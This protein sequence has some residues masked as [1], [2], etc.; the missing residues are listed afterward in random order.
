MTEDGAGPS[1]PLRQL[2]QYFRRARSDA[3]LT[4]DQVSAHMEWSPSK[5]SRLERGQPGKLTNRDIRTL[6]EFL[7]FETEQTAAMLGLAQQAAVKSWWHAFGDLIPENFNVYV[8]MESSARHLEIFRPD[9]IPGLFQTAD[10]TRVLD[11]IYFPSGSAE[12]HDMR[13][14]V[15]M[16]RQKI[17]TRKIKPVT[18]DVV[19]HESVLRTIVGGGAVMAAQLSHL[20]DVSTRPNVSIRVLPFAAGFP[21]GLAV[22]PYVIL[23]FGTAPIEPTV[24]YVENYTGDLYLEGESDL[25]KYRSATAAIQRVALDAVSSRNLLRQMTKEYRQ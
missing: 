13:I 6:C 15:R 4:L 25:Q 3:H 16:K 21:V 19:L 1:L 8:G 22:G 14:D 7:E 12:E 2:G 10:Y 18:L 23:E 11:R 9:I 24:V 17:F 5:L 20:A